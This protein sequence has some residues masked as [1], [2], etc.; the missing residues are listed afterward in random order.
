MSILQESPWTDESP[1]HASRNRLPSPDDDTFADGVR[2]LRES[3]DCVSASVR[4]LVDANDLFTSVLAI[5]VA[6][7]QAETA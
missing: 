7:V 5:L 6:R 1:A 2:G 4:T 3:M